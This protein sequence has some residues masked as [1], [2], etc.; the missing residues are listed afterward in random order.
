MIPTLHWAATN[1]HTPVMKQKLPRPTVI[2]KQQAPK[3]SLAVK[4]LLGGKG[5]C[6]VW[7]VDN[8]DIEENE[9]VILL[10]KKDPNIPT[11]LIA[12]L[13]KVWPRL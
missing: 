13:S 4:T 3:A 11:V 9:G 7:L 8:D 6:L 12:L 2:K 1:G 5:S 10:D